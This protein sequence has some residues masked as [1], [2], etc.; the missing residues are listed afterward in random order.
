LI[1]SYIYKKYKK[2]AVKGRVI[3]RIFSTER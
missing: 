2:K 1:L 3:K